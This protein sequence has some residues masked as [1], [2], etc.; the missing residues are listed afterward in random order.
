M[1]LN[2]RFKDDPN[3]R[4]FDVIVNDELIGGEIFKFNVPGDYYDVE[5]RIPASLT[6]GKKEITVTF[7]SQPVTI[8]ARLFACQTLKP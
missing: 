1:T 3:Q 7:R 8:P 4:L 2:C 6:R 5:Y